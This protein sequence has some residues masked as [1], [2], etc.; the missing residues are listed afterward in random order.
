MLNIIMIALAILTALMA[1]KGR[2]RDFSKY[3]SGS[4]DENVSLT[5]LASKTGVLSATQT[6]SDTTRVS[7]IRCSY[8][9]SD[10]TPI[11]NAGPMIVGVAH[12]DYSLAEVEEWIE[13]TGGWDQGN[14]VQTREVRRRLIRQIGVM[15][16]PAAATG[17]SRLNDGRMLK[18]KLNWL[19]SEG[20]GLNFWWYNSGNAAVA[21][22]VPN[23]IIFGKANLWI[24]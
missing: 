8:T 14:M 1:R 6:V 11:A 23:A 16:T 12:S 18:T 10:W 19:L 7:S 22:T 5:T 15:D 24:Q 20:D 2:R 21:T 13:A 3:L 17:S 4:I 9:L